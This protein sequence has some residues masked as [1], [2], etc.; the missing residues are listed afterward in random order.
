MH[1]KK[2]IKDTNFDGRTK[3]I[4]NKED[5]ENNFKRSKSEILICRSY[6]STTGNISI[7]QVILRCKAQKYIHEQEQTKTKHKIKKIKQ[8]KHYKEDTDNNERV[9]NESQKQGD[10][11]AVSSAR[12]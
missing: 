9:R 2:L 7:I 3:L 10:L 8:K 11:D 6:S 4:M 5:S 1:Y 12:E